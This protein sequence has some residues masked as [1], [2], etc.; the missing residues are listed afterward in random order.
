MRPKVACH[1]LLEKL[2]LAGVTKTFI[3]LRKGKWDIPAYL[4]DGGLVDMHLAYLTVGSTFGPPYTLDQAYPF[5]EDSVVAFGF[6]D[7]LIEPD[8]I[9]VQLLK[10]QAS[11]KADVVLAL[12]VPHDVR[13]MDMVDVDE[14]GRVRAMRIKPEKTNLQYGW[15]CS[16]W[17][18]AF[19]QFM[20]RYLRFN[21]EQQV[22]G[23]K[24]GTVE[25][26]ELSV[27]H[28]IAAAI[29]QG[30][31]VEGLP[32]PN[33]RYLDIGTAHDLARACNTHNGFWATFYP[34]D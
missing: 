26:S 6:P 34:Q 15:I 2:R 17:T 16:V 28:V 27:G 1:Y 18:A 31:H 23:T 12:F 10:R 3:V 25:R 5:V 14:D 11:S 24:R 13:Q 30:L 19:T 9:F 29:Q 32:F 21:E 22:K 4:G 20:H 8:D 7:I 33:G